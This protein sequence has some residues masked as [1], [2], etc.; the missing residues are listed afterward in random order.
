MHLEYFKMMG[1]TRKIIVYL[2][3][4][5][6]VMTASWI[7]F[8]ISKGIDTIELIYNY[9]YMFVVAITIILN[10]KILFQE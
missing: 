7:T 9:V 6:L 5:L 4:L 10:L 3:M 1:R 2:D 8:A